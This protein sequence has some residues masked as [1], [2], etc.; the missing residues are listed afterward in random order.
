MVIVAEVIGLIGGFNVGASNVGAPAVAV[1]EIL[2]STLGFGSTCGR[3]LVTTAGRRVAVGEVV[4]EVV[5][6]GVVGAMQS[7]PQQVAGQLP[8]NSS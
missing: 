5:G 2:V 8:R 4:G 1:T 7:T 6:D 3:G